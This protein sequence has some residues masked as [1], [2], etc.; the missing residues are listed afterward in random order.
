MRG[1]GAKCEV[2]VQGATCNVQGAECKVQGAHAVARRVHS[3]PVAYVVPFRIGTTQPPKAA[4]CGLNDRADVS[5]ARHQRWDTLAAP[6][7]ANRTRG[8]VQ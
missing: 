8:P 5:G 6:I 3:V 1:A 7:T 2:R 4:S